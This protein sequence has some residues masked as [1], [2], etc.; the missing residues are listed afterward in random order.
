MDCGVLGCGIVI[1]QVDTNASDE[2][3]ASNFT[4]EACGTRNWLGYKGG[5]HSR[6]TG[7]GKRQS[8]VQANRNGEKVNSPVQGHNIMCKNYRVSQ[9]RRQHKL[10]NQRHKNLRTYQRFPCGHFIILLSPHLGNMLANIKSF[11]C[12]KRPVWKLS[13]EFP[14]FSATISTV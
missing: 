5:P 4:A 13:T 6:L 10:N 2:N 1:L 12:L 9:S 11:R 14:T 3:A 7:M 8:S